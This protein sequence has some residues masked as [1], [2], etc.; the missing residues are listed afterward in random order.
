MS[1]RKKN[2]V[3]S[4]F[5]SV[6]LAIFL[7]FILAGTSII[8]TVVQQNQPPSSYVR[9]YGPNMATFLQLLDL[10]DMYNSWWFLGL[11]ALFSVNLIVCSLERIP[12]VI[13]LVRKDNLA[14]PVDRLTK[15]GIR[16]KLATELSVPE[17]VDRVSGFLREKGWK[18]AKREREGGVL[19][20][21]QKGAWTRFGVYIVHLSI[22]VILAGAILGSSQVAT[23]IL[24][25]PD[26]A[27]KGSIMLPETSVTDHI[28]SFQNQEKID[29]GFSVRC[30][31]FTIEYYANGMP[32]TYLTRATV[33]D[34]GKEVLTTDIEVNTPLRYKGITFYQSSYQAMRRFVVRLRDQAKKAETTMVVDGGREYSW[35]ETGI[36]FGLLN[37][38]SFGESVRQIKI[39]FAD[40]RAE[41]AIFWV[42]NNQPAR[43]KRPQGEYTMTVK[44]QYATG[45]QVSRDPGVPLVYG[46]CIMMLLGLFVAFFMSHRKLLAYIHEEGGKTV[47]L[48]AGT[49]HKN[50]VGFEKKFSELMR[51]FREQSR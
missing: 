28:Y 2:I 5:A 48:F 27:F 38:K 18:P 12:T 8:G 10:T 16:Q 26:F 44:Q 20:C 34:Q 6:K 46:G 23:R 4:F 40:D 42:N 17:A 43:I 41:P 39:W 14:T 15:M 22:L 32:K 31:Y 1:A 25:R 51:E 13:K 7:L 50:K 47:I 21:G 36:K 3:W 33:I 9:E 45:L 37:V 35:P 19:V 29:L 30:D 49:A 11:L 24:H